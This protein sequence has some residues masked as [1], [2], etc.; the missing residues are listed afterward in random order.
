MH[1][2]LDAH[3]P[4]RL[5]EQLRVAGHEC[6]HT[7][8]LADGNR[9]SDNEISSVAEALCAVV[10]TK[11]D[12]FRIAHQLRRS[13]RRLLLLAVGNYTNQELAED[14]HLVMELIASAFAEPWMVEVRRD[15]RIITPL[16]PEL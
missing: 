15:A 3:T 2:L 16:T 8:V 11:D 4:H 13:P 6:L 7:E 12:D 1:F 10:V 9:T 5:C 14:V